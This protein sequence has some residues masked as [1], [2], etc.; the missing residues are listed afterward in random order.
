MN[1]FRI[2]SI[3]SGHNRSA[4]KVSGKR[5]LRLTAC[6]GSSTVRGCQRDRYSWM[7]KAGG[8]SPFQ[9]KAGKQGD[10]SFASVNSIEKDG[11]FQAPS[12]FCIS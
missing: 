2:R 3:A 1:F 5:H 12:F 10:G 6:F 4:G 11:V 7:A 9:C 8:C